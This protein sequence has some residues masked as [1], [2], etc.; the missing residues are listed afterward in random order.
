MQ[1]R[2]SVVRTWKSAWRWCFCSMLI[3]KELVGVFT[4][5]GPVKADQVV[6]EDGTWSSLF[7]NN[8]GF[9]LPQLSVRACAA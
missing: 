6:L 8:L 3:V 1:N 7:A 4:E 2:V 9:K 5:H